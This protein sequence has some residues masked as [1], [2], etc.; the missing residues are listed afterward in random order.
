MKTN[1]ITISSS[2]KPE[3]HLENL[4]TGHSRLIDLIETSF[5]HQKLFLQI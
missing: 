5:L 4:H 3:L 2:S 1:I